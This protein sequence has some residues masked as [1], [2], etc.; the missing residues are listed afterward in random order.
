MDAVDAVDAVDGAGGR[1][2]P[3]D[4]RTI[5]CV[6][7]GVI[8]GGW[9]AYFLARG[10]RVVAWDPADTAEARLRHLVDRAWPALTELGL[11]DGA[12]A[13][14]LTVE[15]DL[16]TACADTHFVQESAPEDL[17]LKR[18]LL[19]DIDAVTPVDVV[20]SSSTSGYG[21]SEMQTKCAHPERTV[22][23]HPFNPPYLIPLVEVVGGTAT[24]AETVAWTSEFFRHAGKSVI[25][26]EREVP[27]FIANRLQEALWRE[28]LHMVA[29]GEATVEQID[30]SITD[31]PGLRW[32]IHGPMMTFHL[33]GGQGGMAHMLDHFGPSLLSPWTRL[34][35]AELTPELR[36]AV[37]EGCE[38]EAD[39][40]S[41]DDLVAERDRGVIAVLR[42]LGRA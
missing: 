9:V 14:N 2:A 27:G 37:V 21:M 38:R 24:S 41:I 12:S 10:Y 6:G 16:A 39:G 11:S 25:T 36:D 15:R 28:A 26:M 8:G 7:A 1:P 29:A 23:G 35:A 5:T 31:G 19:A 33:A 34:V 42:A 20:I 4:V 30:L 17:E 3:Q 22:V 40:R 13:D 32:P 18:T